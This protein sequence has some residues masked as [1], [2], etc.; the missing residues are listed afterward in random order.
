MIELLNGTIHKTFKKIK[1]NKSSYIFNIFQK[2]LVWYIFY[3][4]FMSFMFK[5][6]NNESMVG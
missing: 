2:K 3:Y 1:Y 5:F 4:F 6:L